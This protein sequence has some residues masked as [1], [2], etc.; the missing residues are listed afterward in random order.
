MFVASLV[1]ALAFTV[2]RL[3]GRGLLRGSWDGA[4]VRPLLGTGILAHLGT[5]ALFLTFRFDLLL[6][7]RFLGPR[8][9]GLYSVSLSLSEILRGLP[10]IGQMIVLARSSSSDLVKTVQETT[11]L[12]V[13]ATFLAGG[14]AA[15]AAYWVVPLVFGGEFAGAV[16][17]FVALVPGV[18]SLAVSYCV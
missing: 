8:A 15:I 14:G 2:V 13:L 1:I 10:E 4:L 6:V 18:V 5:L 12:A 11:R 9:A 3:H 16:V 17:P 7:N